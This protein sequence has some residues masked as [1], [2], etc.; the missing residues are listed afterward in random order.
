M[1]RKNPF[2][3]L[4]GILFLLGLIA[5]H[6]LPAACQEQILY[7]FDGGTGATPYAGL[8][9]DALGNLYGTTETGGSYGYGAVFELTP[10]QGGTWTETV[11]YSFGPGITGGRYPYGTLIFDTSGNLY[12]TTYGGGGCGYG[13]VFEL[14][15]DGNGGWTEKALHNFMNNHKDGIHPYAGVV[16]DAAGNLYGATYSGGPSE[17]GTVFELTAKGNGKWS[18]HILHSFAGTDGANPYASLILDASGNLYGT[19][20]SGGAQGVGAVF[21]V[22]PSS[23]VSWPETVLYSFA[24]NGIDGMNPRGNLVFDGSGNLYGT[25]FNGGSNGVG[26]AFELKKGNDTWFESV[27]FNFANDGEAGYNPADGLTFS[28][29]NLYGTATAG[30]VGAYG[31]VFQ[32]G[33]TTEMESWSEIVLYGFSSGADGAN[34]YA[35]V[36]FDGLGNLYGTTTSGGNNLDGTVFEITP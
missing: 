36:I 25:T 15:P 18:E 35:G 29:G 33:P 8:V 11:L 14:M 12:G 31:T 1:R 17:L 20:W 26:S 32:L 3:H 4:F 21:Q 28:L 9:F 23:N 34:P 10:G 30:G 6:P 2:D 19:T 13:T 27:L 24:N 16:L 5:T 7:S 22:A